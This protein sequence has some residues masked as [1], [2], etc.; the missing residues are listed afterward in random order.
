[1]YAIFELENNII[2]QL[3]S[4]W[5]VR[6]NRDELVEFQVDGTLGSA[7]VGL[8]GAKIQPRNA[9]PKPVWNPDLRDEHNYQADWIE[10]PEN[11]TFDNGFKVQWE[12]FIRHVLADTE[13]TFDL[14][15][16]ARGVNL[17]EKALQSM[18]Q[19]QRIS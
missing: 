15:A 17:S 3:N 6:V 8:F 12:E 4:S 14:A 10:L 11:E 16:G 19:G 13:Y 18:D 7:V 9:T 1:A 5:V 2:V